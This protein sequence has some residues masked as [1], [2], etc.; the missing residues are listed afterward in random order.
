MKRDSA[1]GTWATGRYRARIRKS[2]RVM[3]RII[4]KLRRLHLSFRGYVGQRRCT[5]TSAVQHRQNSRYF[6]RVRIGASVSRRVWEGANQRKLTTDVRC[7][8][9][10]GREA[11]LHVR[12]SWKMTWRARENRQNCTAEKRVSTRWRGGMSADKK[13]RAGE[14][15]ALKNDLTRGTSEREF[16]FGLLGANEVAEFRRGPKGY[17]GR[18]VVK[19]VTRRRNTKRRDKQK[20]AMS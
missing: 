3:R 6:R 9:R 11:E 20:A 14:I 12:W 7:A 15:G 8:R 4:L 13:L 18:T 19:T 1:S 17:Y 2:P 10:R 5:L 16:I